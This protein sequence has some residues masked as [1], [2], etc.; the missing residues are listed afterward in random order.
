MTKKVDVMFGM[1]FGSEGKGLIAGHLGMNGGYTHVVNVNMPNAGHT[2]V[3]DD[4]EEYMFKV[5]PNG[6]INPDVKIMLG[7]DSVFSAERLLTEMQMLSKMSWDRL[8]IHENA[9]ILRPEHKIAEA[10][11]GLWNRIGSTAQGS[12]AAMV[13]K[14]SR[15]DEAVIKFDPDVFHSNVVSHEQWLEEISNAKSILL[16]GCQGY[17]LGLNAGFYPYCTSRDCTPGRLLAGA[18]IPFQWV[19]DI[20][21]VARLHPIR[22][23]GNS[24]PG[25]SD[26]REMSWSELGLEPEKTTVTKR[27]RRIFEYSYLQMKSAIISCQPTKV[28]LNFCN[29]DPD[30]SEAII[31]E[32]QALLY[33][34][35]PSNSH[36]A[37]TGWGPKDGDVKH[38]L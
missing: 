16:E 2:Y 11:S 29:Y 30:L 14:I 28:F 32:I 37:W 25:Y 33:I 12:S 21:G 4:G 1:Q 6:S 3:T 38:E 8:I 35:G 27:N 10:E 24:G 5:L 26:Q 20:I 36:V 22:V 9:C 31:D 19:R 18:G 23:G 34:Y 7:P 13:H 15:A 17:S